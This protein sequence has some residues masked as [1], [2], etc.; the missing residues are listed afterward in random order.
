MPSVGRYLLFYKICMHLFIWKQLKLVNFKFRTIYNFRTLKKQLK[1]DRFFKIFP[2]FFAVIIV[3]IISKALRLKFS[4]K[5]INPVLFTEKKQMPLENKTLK[6]K[7]DSK[8][9]ATNI[10][11]KPTFLKKKKKKHY[12]LKKKGPQFIKITSHSFYKKQ[13]CMLY[14]YLPLIICC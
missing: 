10:F 11:T 7:I 12:L 14:Y 3:I 4:E 6:A 8:E 2:F 9:A 5:E 1:M 13:Q